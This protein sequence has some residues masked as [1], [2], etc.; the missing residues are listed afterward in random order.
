M[1]QSNGADD[2]FLGLYAK[3]YRDLYKYAVML[4]V[5]HHDAEDAMQNASQVMWRK[6]DEYRSDEPFLPWARRIVY[7]EVLKVRER[8]ARQSLQLSEEVLSLL[9]V[10][11]PQEQAVLAAQREALVDCITRLSDRERHLVQRRYASEATLVELADN[12][13]TTPNTLYNSLNRIR[14][15]LFECVNRKL[16]MEGLA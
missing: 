4:A 15:K 10:E 6:F 13:N 3:S 11:E 12:L 2:A 5:N 7:F 9:A 8:R 16:R 1:S 14:R